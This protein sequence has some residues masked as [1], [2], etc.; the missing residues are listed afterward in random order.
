MKQEW[1]IRVTVPAR[2]PEPLRDMIFTQV[3]D[4]AFTS[5]PEERDWDIDV[6]ASLGSDL[7]H[8]LAD[9]TDWD[10][11]AYYLGRTLGLFADQNFARDVKHVFW[12]E[13]P[14]GSCLGA[15]LRWLALGGVL[16]VRNDGEIGAGDTQ[17][18]WRGQP[19][20]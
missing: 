12:S 1:E 7:A 9:W 4:A 15:A 14:L 13:N 11:A 10:L 8:A 6:S 20:G 5:Q 17:F 3:A 18:R 19:Q 2:V 16:D